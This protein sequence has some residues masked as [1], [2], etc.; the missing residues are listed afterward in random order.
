M[1]K[2]KELTMIDAPVERCFDLA[3]TWKCIWREMSTQENPPLPWVASRAAKRTWLPRVVREDG[4]LARAP[5]KGRSKSASPGH[6]RSRA[7]NR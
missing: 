6:P 1:V 7:P 3:R 5:G 2:L 4:W